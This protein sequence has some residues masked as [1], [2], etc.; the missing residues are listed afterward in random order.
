MLKFIYRLNKKDEKHYNSI[1]WVQDEY[2]YGKNWSYNYA[3]F[4]G[5]I[6]NPNIQKNSWV[7]YRS[8]K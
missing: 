1:F 5:N 7:Q 8:P 6:V 3:D 2:F 4:W